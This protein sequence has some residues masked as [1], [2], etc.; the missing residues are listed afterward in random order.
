MG[1]KQVEKLETVKN[2]MAIND[3]I[4]EFNGVVGD[5]LDIYG[6]IQDGMEKS[7]K[8]CGMDKV[9]GA[10]LKEALLSL[11]V[12][13]VSDL[14]MSLDDLKKQ[15]G[16]KAEPPFIDIKCVD[17]YETVFEAIKGWIMAFIDTKERAEAF[18]EKVEALPDKAK[19]IGENAKTEIETSD[20]DL[21]SKA[22]VVK[23][24][25]SSVS[26]IKDIAATILD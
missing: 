17:K 19:N 7:L 13:M 21:M 1:K 16:F 15:I 10:G 8:A 18:S 20:L 23:D 5:W 3:F 25:L 26:K 11:I 2:G 9:K 22:K 12:T 14:N 6:S 24:T 4:G